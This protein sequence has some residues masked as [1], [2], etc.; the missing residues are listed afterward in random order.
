MAYGVGVELMIGQLEMD[1]V[2]I[3]HYIDVQ[4][5]VVK[6][7]EVLRDLGIWQNIQHG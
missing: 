4:G 3:T 1:G 7:W 6:W 2:V 5:A